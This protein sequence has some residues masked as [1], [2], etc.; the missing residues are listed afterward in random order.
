M[1]LSDS[2]FAVTVT[3]SLCMLLLA[4]GF[5]VGMLYQKSQTLCYITLT[6]G[7]NKIAH[8]IEGEMK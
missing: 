1:K 5:G 3:I 6:D 4:V 7:A 8:Q 2:Q